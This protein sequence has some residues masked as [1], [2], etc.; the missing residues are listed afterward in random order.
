MKA[1]RQ[2]LRFIS[3]YIKSPV[4]IVLLSMELLFW[5]LIIKILKIFSHYSNNDIYLLKLVKK[6]RQS[7]NL[8]CFA[9]E[10]LTTMRRR[11]GVGGIQKKRLEDKK[12]E[13]KGDELA[14]N[15]VNLR[16]SFDS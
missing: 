4:S 11:V 7:W 13:A 5:T 3:T 14:E 10:A 12:F 6:R 1:A 16:I 15:Q 2:L 9:G 8:Y